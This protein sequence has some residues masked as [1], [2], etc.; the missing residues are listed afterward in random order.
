MVTIF[1]ALGEPLKD[2]I[3]DKKGN[4]II[5]TAK[6]QM[7]ANH[8]QHVNKPIWNALGYEVPITTLTTV[9]KKITLQKF[10]EISPAD[11]MPVRVGQGSWSSSLLTYRTFDIADDFT[12]GIINTGGNNSRLASADTGVDAVPIKV[13]NWAKSIGWTIMDLEQAARAGNWDLVTSK[14]ESRKKNWDLGIQKLAFLGVPG[15]D[16]IRGWYTLPGVTIN[17]TLIT[18]PIKNMDAAALNVFLQNLVNTYRDNARRTAWPALFA[19]PESDYLGLAAPSSSE[20]PIK[21][22][23][24][25]IEET[26][27]VMTKNPNFKVM[28]NAYGDAQYHSDIA[29]I[30]GKQCYVM[31]SYDEKSL[32]L[33]IPV[34]YTNTLANSIDNFSFQN[35]G[36]GQFT[37]AGVYVPRETIYYQY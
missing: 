28:P 6:E 21:S 30:A 20:F 26:L 33:D 2:I 16:A 22:K 35:V 25:L 32:R 14:E 31:S 24:E 1:N 8:L 19:I 5:L 23:L 7:L 13:N 11:F 9:M 3:L 37:G 27:K 4:P 34:D 36:Y 10:F 18:Q 12:S 29:S 17:T 15:V